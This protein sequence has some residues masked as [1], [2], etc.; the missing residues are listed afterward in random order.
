MGDPVRPQGT[1]GFA[2]VTLDQWRDAAAILFF[3]I[4]GA[5][6]ESLT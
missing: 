4:P 5:L 6:E 2:T 3:V 1:G